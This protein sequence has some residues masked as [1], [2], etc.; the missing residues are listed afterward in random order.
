MWFVFYSEVKT[1]D[2]NASGDISGGDGGCGGGGGGAG[3]AGGS[4]G[5]SGGGAAAG[6]GGD[7]YS[8]DDVNNRLLA[9]FDA[10]V[11]TSRW[12]VKIENGFLIINYFDNIQFFI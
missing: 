2:G 8:G 5:G 10:Q 12:Q 4:S 3:G 6:G 7:D 9:A 1:V 11:N